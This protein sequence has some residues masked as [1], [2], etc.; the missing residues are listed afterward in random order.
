MNEKMKNPW[1]GLQAYREGEILYGRDEDILRLSGQVLS[2]TDTVLYG[3][4]F[5]T[6]PSLTC[7]RSTFLSA[8]ISAEIQK[9]YHAL[10][11]FGVCFGF[12]LCSS[13]L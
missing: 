2:D 10:N 11:R 1:R 7:C 5:Q 9:P 12:S 4:S 13:L 8:L 3:K 6:D